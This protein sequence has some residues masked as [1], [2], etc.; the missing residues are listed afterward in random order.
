MFTDVAVA[1]TFFGQKAGR[2]PK[3]APHPDLHGPCWPPAG[4]GGRP[5][6]KGRDVRWERSFLPAPARAQRRSGTKG[7]MQGGSPFTRFLII[8]SLK[9]AQ[10]KSNRY[11]KLFDS[12]SYLYRF[13]LD[14]EDFALDPSLFNHMRWPGPTNF[15]PWANLGALLWLCQKLGWP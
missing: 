6:P 7:Q 15:R 1:S 3:G 4:S 9:T 5:F 10:T 14:F 11:R 2:S 8:F 13:D 12:D